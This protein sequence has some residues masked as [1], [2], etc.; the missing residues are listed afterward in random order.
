MHAASVLSGW[1]MCMRMCMWGASCGYGACSVQSAEGRGASTLWYV[2]CMAWGG[3][4]AC[5]PC[6][7]PLLTVIF[8]ASGPVPPQNERQRPRT[9]P[10]TMSEHHTA[11]TAAMRGAPWYHARIT[12]A[13]GSMPA[14]SAPPRAAP[15]ASTRLAASAAAC[16]PS[17][18]TTCTHTRVVWV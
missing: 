12:P 4:I 18:G 13:V 5:M 14:R 15:P 3:S 17:C 7:L 8:E 1:S 11:C 10:R 6:S 9:A 2:A 16:A